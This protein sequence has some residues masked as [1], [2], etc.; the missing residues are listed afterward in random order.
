MF[1]CEICE[2]FGLREFAATYLTG[3]TFELCSSCLD[4]EIGAG[5]IAMFARFPGL[6]AVN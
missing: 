3:E 2:D 4:M 6:A 1:S 5:N